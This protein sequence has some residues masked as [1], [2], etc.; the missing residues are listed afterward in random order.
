MAELLPIARKVLSWANEGEAVE[1]V[2]VHDRDTEIRVYEGEIEQFTASESQGVGVRV[3]VDNKQGFAYAGSLDEEVLAETL[4]EARD[5][6]TF[7]T[8]DEFLGLAE[9]D[10]VEV[11]SLDLFN[12]AVGDMATDAKIDLAIQLEAQARKSDPRISGIESADYVDSISES[13][14]VS[15]A[16]LEVT[17]RDSASY[18]TVS[19]LAEENGD[20]QIGFGF[21]VG[22]NPAELDIARAAADAGDRATRLLGATQPASEKVTIIFDPFVTAQFLAIL[23]GTMSGESVM[24]GYSLFANRMDEDCLLYTSPSPRD[25]RGSRM[26]SSA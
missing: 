16:G 19:A 24:K 7:G 18:V 12:T 26:P 8:P 1:V 21:S 25:Q 23:G 11:P 17:S 3:I 9:P 20:T 22:R 13:A 6:A 5:N 2:A 10:G 14:L 4:A 15:T